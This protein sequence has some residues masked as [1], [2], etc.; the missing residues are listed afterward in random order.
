MPVYESIADLV[1]NTPI[2]DVSKLS[3]NPRVRILAKLEGQNP[4]GSVKDRAA[5]WMLDE[6]EKDGS[7]K[8]GQTIL[9][10]SSGYTGIALAM[11]S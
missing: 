5:R 6:A 1:G 4:G 9:E 11:F 2:V 7:L 3:P 8:P 10:S